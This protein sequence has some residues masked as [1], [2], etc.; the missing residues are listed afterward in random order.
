MIY[1]ELTKNAVKIMFEAHR[2]Q[3]DKSG[4]PYVFHPWHVAE[5]MT[6]ELSAAAALLHD[7]VEDTDMTP[8]DL[9]ARGIPEPVLEALALLTHEDGVDYDAYVDRIATNAIARRV[10]MSDLQHNMDLTRMAPADPDE[11][12]L[13]RVEKYQRNYEKLKRLEEEGQQL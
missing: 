1:T 13:Q 2:D 3:V 7:V 9:R 6:D 10:K 11:D 12:A 5:S 4:L 8:D